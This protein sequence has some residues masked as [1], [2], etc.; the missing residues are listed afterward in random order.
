MVLIIRT[1]Q[2]IIDIATCIQGGYSRSDVKAYIQQCQW[3]S[4]STSE[5][6]INA[7]IDLTVHLLCMLDVGE[8]ENAY[9]G[10]KKLLRAQGSLQDFVQETLLEAASLKNEGTKLDGTFKM[11][12]VVR[13]AGFKLEPTSNL[14]DH[15]RLR[16]VN[17]TIE[18]F[19]HASFLMAHTQSSIFPP[20]LVNETL[21]TLAFLFP[22]GERETE[23]W[24]KKQDGPE[25]LD[26]NILCCVKVDRRI[27]DY[28]YWHDRL[29]I[30][31]TEF[32]ETRPSN[33]TQW[34]NYRRDVSQWYP[35]WVAISLTVLFSLV[36]S[37]EG[38]LQ[39]YKAYN[40]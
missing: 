1:H 28:K 6:A 4:D 3:T 17:K 30:L 13:I 20:G 8:F 11:Y 15:L 2:H 10:R 7:S 34:W 9:S 31:K 19:H 14:R 5:S 21:T 22:E 32:D 29:I 35:L 23:K 16:D 40:P 24:Y 18:V 36:Q 33:V 39:V 27:R 25:E 37:I 38:A 26:K 12:N